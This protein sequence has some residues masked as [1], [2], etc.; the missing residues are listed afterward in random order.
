MPGDDLAAFESGTQGI[1]QRVA[2]RVGQVGSTFSTLDE[3]YR[4]NVLVEAL[5][6][7]APCQAINPSA[8]G[9]G[10]G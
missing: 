1:G 7:E 2:A 6:N 5:R 8:D 10:P 4:D 9:P 3:R